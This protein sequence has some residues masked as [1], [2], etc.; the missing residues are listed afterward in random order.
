MNH[1]RHRGFTLIEIAIVVFI[2]GLIASIAII[3]FNQ[4]QKD[5][6]D[7]K[8]TTD[9]VALENALGT[10]YRDNNEYPA[11]CASGDNLACDASYLTASL[12]PQYISS[13]PTDPNGGQYKYV[14]GTN[15]VGFGFLIG[16]ETQPQCKAGYNVT[17]GWWGSSVPICG[18]PL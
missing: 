10:Y 11:V 7:R 4:V 18:S 12:T 5:S 9:I 13:I 1:E 14:R 2:I 17:S 15:G 3:A 16:F 6:R 8:R